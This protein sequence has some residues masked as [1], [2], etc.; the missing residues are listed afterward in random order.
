MVY[1][2]VETKQHTSKQTLGKRNKKGNRNYHKTNENEN[3]HQI[4]WD[5]AK[6]V[7]RRKLKAINTYIKKVAIS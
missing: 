2:L 7:L 4:L 5:A 3:K 1:R 6:T